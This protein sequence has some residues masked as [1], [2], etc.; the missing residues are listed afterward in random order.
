MYPFRPCCCDQSVE[1]YAREIEAADAASV[2]RLVCSFAPSLGPL[3]VLR[4]L[5]LGSCVNRG[6]HRRRRDCKGCECL[7]CA[8]DVVVSTDCPGQ[9]RTP[10]P[11]LACCGR[12]DVLPVV[13]TR[14][15]GCCVAH[16]YDTGVPWSLRCVACGFDQAV[17]LLCGLRFSWITAALHGL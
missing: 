7:R 17:R 4:S 5:L 11:A 15:C 8:V 9:M 6:L 14:R 2:G 16:N 13:L 1:Q 3:R 10:D 12:C